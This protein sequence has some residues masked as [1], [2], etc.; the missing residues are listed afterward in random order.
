METSRFLIYA[1][2][3]PRSGEWRYVGKSCSGMKRPQEH[4]YPSF[5]KSRTRKNNW[6][7]SLQALGLKPEIQVV[8]EFVSAVELN[9]AEKEWIAAARAAGVRLT[10]LADGGEGAPGIPCDDAKRRSIALSNMEAKRRL[11]PAQEKELCELY[12]AGNTTYQL[13]EKFGMERHT[14]GR[15]LRKNGV[16]IRKKTDASRRKILPHQVDE[17]VAFYVGGMSTKELAKKYETYA[18][19]VWAQLK[20]RGVMRSRSEAALNSFQ[21]EV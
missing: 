7:K 8:E 17:M 13:S 2:V 11:T 5:L 12:L 10:N 18:A 19:N 14:V 15:W 4:F 6:I 20:Q 16:A 3:D 21:R 1:L 9:T